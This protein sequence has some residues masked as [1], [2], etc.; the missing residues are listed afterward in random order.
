MIGRYWRA[1]RR[2]AHDRYGTHDV[3]FIATYGRVCRKCN[4]PVQW[5]EAE[6]R[7]RIRR[8]FDL[9]PPIGRAR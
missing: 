6:N 8:P 2:W 1:L 4:L 9:H 3:T 5:V 7:Y